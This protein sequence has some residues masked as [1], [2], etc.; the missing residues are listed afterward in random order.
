ML[1]QLFRGYSKSFRVVGCEIT[2]SSVNRVFIRPKETDCAV[3]TVSAGQK[4][5][6]DNQ[7]IKATSDNE[8]FFT[9]SVIW[10]PSPVRNI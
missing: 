8:L 9:Y 4:N 2:P 3:P 1:I 10:A 6:Q 5:F 7:E